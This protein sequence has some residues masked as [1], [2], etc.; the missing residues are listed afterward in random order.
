[1]PYD[2]TVEID[3][4]TESD[5]A[6]ERGPRLHSE[7]HLALARNPYFTVRDLRVELRESDVVLSGVLGSYFHKQ[8]AQETVLSIHGVRRVHNEICVVNA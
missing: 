5:R 2:C 1:M 6:H 3:N 4:P 8:M 7:V